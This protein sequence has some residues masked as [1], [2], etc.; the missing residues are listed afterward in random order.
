LSPRDRLVTL[1]TVGRN[2]QGQR[3]ARELLARSGV[4]DVDFYRAQ[5]PDAPTD[6]AGAVAHFVEEGM[7]RL[8]AFHPAILPGYLDP[9]IVAA[10]S[11]GD[12]GDVFRLLTVPGLGHP[13]A[14]WFSPS[15]H[16]TT[17]RPG[18]R[19]FILADVLQ[20]LRTLT[21]D[22]V[23]H[24]DP[25]L[26]FRTS[27]KWSEVR[28]EALAA[29]RSIQ[30][31]RALHRPRS[32]DD[33]DDV[34]EKR[35]IASTQRRP[36]AV[37]DEMPVVS[38]VM[39]AWNRES[40]ISAA[41][42]SVQA[43]TFAEWELIIVDDG[44]TD[45]TVEVAEALAVADSRIRVVR[46]D[47]AG[48]CAARN[49]AIDLAR[50]TYVAFLDT[51][52]AWR[53]G[54]L[55]LAVKAMHAENLSF[56]Y[57]GTRLST[58][59]GTVRYRGSQ[60][61]RDELLLFNHI[62]LNVA[63]VRTDTLRQVGGFDTTLRRWVDHDLAIRVSAVCTPTYL[64][65]IGCDYDDTDD[66]LPRI[67]T[68]EG[69]HW[70]FVVLGKAWCDWEVAAQELPQRVAGRISIVMPVLSDVP[71]TLAAID[72]VLANSAEHDIEVI[73]VDNGSRDDTGLALAA[74]LCRMP[75]VRWERL[76]RN[77]NFGIGSNVGAIRSTGS[78]ILFL[79]N[80]TLVRPS[81][82]EPLIRR[83]EDPEVAGVQPLLVYDDDTIQSA[84][85]FFPSTF[86][87]PAHF[88][89][90][91]PADDAHGVGDLRFS[92][93]TA[94]AL[95]MRIE[96]VV[97]LRGFDPVFVNGMEDVDLCLRATAGNDRY[98][99]VEPT[100]IVTHLESRTPGRMLR[101]PENRTLL[102][103]RWCGRLPQ[104]QDPYRHVGFEITQLGVDQFRNPAP[105]P[106]VQRRPSVTTH[107]ELGEIPA[108]RWGIRNPATPGQR[109]DQWGDTPFA[110]H[111]VS[112]LRE[113]GQQAV[114]TR[115]A[116]PL[117][118]TMA[119]DDVSVVIRGLRRIDPQ[120]GKINVLWVISHPEMV[121]LAE[122]TA[123]DVVFAA[124]VPWAAEM[125]AAS[126]RPVLPLL[127]AT[128]PTR[129]H[130]D[131]HPNPHSDRVLFV[132]QARGGGVPRKIVT[133]A[134]AGE[135]N[136]EVW[137]PNWSNLIPESAIHGEYL[138]SGLLPERYRGAARVLSDHW[139][140]M[141]VAGFI[142]NRVFDA[143][144]AG[145]R[146]ISDK[147]SGIEEL[148]GGA[149]HTYETV[150]ELAYLCSTEGDG[151][152]PSDEELI[153]L[154]RQVGTDHSF[155]NRA[156]AMLTEVLRARGDL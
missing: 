93:A 143:V 105:R 112:A 67:T 108:L 124:S 90:G 40:V 61:S 31:Q 35:W 116:T 17:H 36:V 16:V 85:T 153:Q 156:Q 62:D 71:M 80:D 136:V 114:A 77:Y 107:P 146:V 22:T 88:L 138:P 72:S 53:P 111:L 78:H 139:D 70:E 104:H 97:A 100:S 54:Y 56:A 125:S 137:G 21:D 109:G 82:L 39:P 6:L 115:F 103:Q 2:S 32:S 43:Q 92:A 63:M 84:G 27:M 99:A 79:N 144:A 155:V 68:S 91:F 19:R 10:W 42:T 25:K 64:P 75:R 44:S 28:S 45:A 113:H 154:A 142:S 29:A 11:R 140:D 121:T 14:P 151:R 102:A 141:A 76:P 26:G 46:A 66:G 59:D 73:V 132:G 131:A 5:Q 69:D 120:P 41:I 50:G 58:A 96:D 134:I 18:P 150:D 110:A 147:V 8:A 127:Q 4:F 122:I 9:R 149:V 65:F 130:P 51:D 1:S 118:S 133:D 33:W 49:T 13:W 101:V 34:A 81:W 52:N 89:T 152:F 87:I 55:E 145:G 20:F 24:P 98:F 94:A 129:F 23:V 83:L 126:G 148:F 74:G 117:P 119:F 7:P 37:A 86:T 47:H 12:L 48:V 15:A 38:I 3:L 95:L 106:I 123:F 128:D 60:C 30:K 135:V 57:C